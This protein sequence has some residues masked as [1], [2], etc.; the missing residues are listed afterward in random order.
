MPTSLSPSKVEAFTSCPLAFRFSTIETSARAGQHPHREGLARPPGARAAV[1]TSTR[2]QRTPSGRPRGRSTRRRPSSQADP[3][4]LHARR[5]GRAQATLEGRRAPALVERYFRLEDPTAI[6]PERD[7]T[8]ARGGGRRHH[9][10]RHHRPARARRRRRA[11]R[12]RL[13]DRPRAVAPVRAAAP[14]RRALLR[15]PVRAGPRR[16]PGRDPPALPRQRRDHHRHPSEQSVRFLPK[17]TGAVWQAIEQGLRRPATS[18]PRPGP[19]CGGCALPA[20]V[21]GV[22][23]RPRAGPRSRRRSRSAAEP[24]PARDGG[25]ARR[26][27][28]RPRA[29]DAK[30]SQDSK[31]RPT[32]R[33]TRRRPRTLQASAG[34]RR[35][36]RCADV[37]L[38]RLPRQPVADTVFRHRRQARRL[39]SLI[40]HLV[41]VSRGPHHGR[42]AAPTPVPCGW[43]ALGAESPDRQ[44]GPSS[45]CSSARGRRR[46]VTPRYHGPAPADEQSFPSG[47]ASAAAFTAVAAERAG[48]RALGAA[49]V[50]PSPP[51]SA[52]AR[53]YVRIH[54]ASDVVAGVAIGWPWPSSPSSAAPPDCRAGPQ[55]W[56]DAA[57]YAG[58]WRPVARAH[59]AR[60]FA[61]T[62][63]YRCPFARNRPRARGRPGCA[64]GADWDV[65]FLPFSLGQVHVEEGEPDVWEQPEQD[66]RL[67]RPAGRRRRP[68]HARPSS[69]STCTRR[70]SSTATTHAG[71]PPRGERPDARARRPT[72]STPTPCSPRSP[73]GRP[74][75]TVEKEHDGVRRQPRGVG[76]ADVH[77][78]R[79][80]GVRPPDGPARRRRR[81]RP[82]RRSSASSTCSRLADLNEFKHTSIPR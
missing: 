37:A 28:P 26:R 10:A 12:H 72:A 3:E 68:R 22:R 54:H 46:R 81:G 48:R 74:L 7:R 45:G 13:Q 69:S 32:S 79:P 52:T 21:P 31:R 16:A 56:H 71:A 42:R 5:P 61:V 17:R 18:G 9:A 8:A 35:F 43:P 29:P 70:C 77:R 64:A 15:V 82:A 33:R 41:G 76:R 19:L 65:T 63:D 34:R 50:R 39:V 49:V 66:T 59:D 6:H 40:W 67:A 44:P 75:A 23:R 57:E 53:A 24:G 60:Q 14:R 1:R 62:W 47:H 25:R 36:D 4:Y 51:S 11:R 55:P 80:G 73:T 58:R 38:E 20:V 78:R 27:P 30:D 2:R